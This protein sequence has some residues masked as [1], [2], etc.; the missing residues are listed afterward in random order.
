MENNDIREKDNINKI[1]KTKNKKFKNRLILILIIEAIFCILIAYQ[2]LP[3]IKNGGS[4]IS[5]PFDFLAS[6]LRK[7]SLS[8]SL[9][10]VF[11]IILYA[12]IC[13]IPIL[14]F[15]RLKIQKKNTKLDYMLIILSFALFI[16]IYAMINPKTMNLNNIFANTTISGIIYSFILSYLILKYLEKFYKNDVEN[17]SLQ[18]YIK[19]TLIVLTVFLVGI[20]FAVHFK[21]FLLSTSHIEPNGDIIDILFRQPIGKPL[22]YIL[23]FIRTILNILPYILDIIIAFLIIDLIDERIID[24]YSNNSLNA[25]NKLAK[26]CKNFLVIIVIANLIFNIMQLVFINEIP[27]SDFKFDLPVFSIIFA[28]SSLI[29]AKFMR[30]NKELKDENDLFV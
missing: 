28:V 29:L 21:E 4:M 14:I 16:F 23:L 3:I 13:L 19:D 24:K 30:E 5:L 12:L 20:I 17:R 22:P 9:G 25:S 7:L 8:S 27:P 11:A 26:N 18:K 1:Q 2:E 10:N 15:I 6:I